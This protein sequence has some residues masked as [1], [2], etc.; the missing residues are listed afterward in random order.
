MSAVAALTAARIVGLS[1][2]ALPLAMASEPASAP[3]MPPQQQNALVQKYC[4]VCH[5]DAARNGGLSLEHFDAAHPDAAVAAMMLGKLKTG[6]IG[7]AGLKRPDDLTIQAWIAATSAQAA[8][9]KRWS[10]NRVQDPVAKASV[11]SASIVQQVAAA[12]SADVP[13]SYRLTV[14]CQPDTRQAV[15]ELS[16]SPIPP[17]SGQVFSALMDDAALSTYAVEGAEKMGDGSGGNAGMASVVLYASA[18]AAKSTMPLPERTLTI[19]GALA[20]ETVVFPFAELTQTD[21]DSLAAC[22]PKR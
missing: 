11:V 20:D 15:M 12:R 2:V 21:R 10:V 18:A 16:W 14:T 7:A 4:A 1:I 19:R 22:F 13:D 3:S 8:G 6:A 5:T 17:K 9:A